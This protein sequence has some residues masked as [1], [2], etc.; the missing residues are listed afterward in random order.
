[1]SEVTVRADRK[2]RRVRMSLSIRAAEF[3]AEVLAAYN[4]GRTVRDKGL[5]E[6]E[7]KLWDAVRELKE[8][9]DV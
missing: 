7:G 4:V 3:Y 5:E 8:A 6:D 2:S 9:Y 1:M